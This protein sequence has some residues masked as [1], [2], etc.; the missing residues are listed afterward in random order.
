MGFHSCDSMNS[1]TVFLDIEV[2]SKKPDFSD[3]IIVA[4]GIDGDISFIYRG[5]DLSGNKSLHE[6]LSAEKD[7]IQRFWNEF[8]PRVEDADIVH[9]IGWNIINFDLPLLYHKLVHYNIADPYTAWLFLFH[10]ANV[11]DLRQIY[12]YKKGFRLRGT[13]LTNA[14]KELLSE[15]RH[16]EGSDV[17]TMLEQRRYYD[18]FMHL[19]DDLRLIRRLYSCLRRGRCGG[20]TS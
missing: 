13:S 11:L 9:L 14:A 6:V 17:R 16:S 5:F 19:Q 18:V 8:Y 4:I 3:A 10:R 12:I 15:D 20:F 2:Y 7:V 1:T